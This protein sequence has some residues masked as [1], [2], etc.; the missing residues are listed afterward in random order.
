MHEKLHDTPLWKADYLPA[1]D[2]YLQAWTFYKG[3]EDGAITAGRYALTRD[4]PGPVA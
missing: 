4:A 1:L 3:L 2:E